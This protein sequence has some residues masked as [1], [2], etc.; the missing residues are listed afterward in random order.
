[1]GDVIHVVNGHEGWTCCRFFRLGPWPYY[2]PTVF[3]R[4]LGPG[5]IPQCKNKEVFLLRYVERAGKYTARTTRD[6]I[7]HLVGI[8]RT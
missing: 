1:M 6:Q 4:A 8:H 5:I 2:S 7:P 3:E